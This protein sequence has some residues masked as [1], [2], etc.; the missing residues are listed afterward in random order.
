[1]DL[2]GALASS[3]PA[4]VAVPALLPDWL[5]AETLMSNL[6]TFAFWAA[7]AIIF[8]ECG[9]FL[10]FMPGD[11]LLFV[12]GMFIATGAIDMSIWLACLLLFLAAVLGNA[13]G[14]WIGY[15]VGPK[16]FSRP[17]SRI[18]KPVYL[19]K[20][21]EFFEKYG[22]AAIILARFVPIV[23]TFITA[24]A[25][26][27]RMSFVRF[28][29][30]SAIGGFLWAVGVTLL[31]YWLGNVEF[32]KNNVEVMLVVVVLVSVVP[33]G[34]EYLRHRRKARTAPQG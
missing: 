20:T 1:M 30:F 26:A 11:S 7:L 5:N 34:I 21:H 9:L 32:V 28:I 2:P 15:A 16:L 27:G 6:G 33:I 19:D 24:V 25:G 22:A 3:I 23:R 31:G 13:V 18:F 8:A 4:V 10:F 17:N 14:Y 12:V 29:T